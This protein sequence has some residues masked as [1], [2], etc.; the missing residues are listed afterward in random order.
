MEQSN[1]VACLPL[2]LSLYPLDQQSG[3]EAAEFIS[4]E[5]HFQSTHATPKRSLPP[6][7]AYPAAA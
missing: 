6:T 5:F 2:S 4:A 1:K 3:K 7:K